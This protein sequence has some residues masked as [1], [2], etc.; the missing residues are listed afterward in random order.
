MAFLWA[1]AIC[2]AVP[3]PP[4][5][6]TV[7]A[8]NSWSTCENG[9]HGVTGNNP[10]NTTE[11]GFGSTSTKNGLVPNY[12]DPARGVAA[13]ARTL[14][15]G[16]YPTILGAIHRGNLASVLRN[17]RAAQSELSTWGTRMSCVL[18]GIG[19]AAPGTG[20]VR[21][22]SMRG[23]AVEPS[24]VGDIPLPLVGVLGGGGVLVVVLGVLGVGG[25]LVWRQVSA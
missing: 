9:A 16:R 23:Q 8:L 17:S 10:L 15:N 5:P 18:N 25:Y 22:L 7:R 20:N 6:S 4:T 1:V 13:T 11:P 21:T 14:R 3:G 24:S 12:P 2:A 19:G